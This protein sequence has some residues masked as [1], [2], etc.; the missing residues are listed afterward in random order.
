MCIHAFNYR[1]INQFQHSLT[2]C[3][4]C[5]WTVRLSTTKISNSD[6]SRTETSFMP[7]SHGQTEYHLGSAVPGCGHFRGDEFSYAALDRVRDRRWDEHWASQDMLNN[8]SPTVRLLRAGTSTGR[9]VVNFCLHRF[10]GSLYQHHHC[11]VGF[12]LLAE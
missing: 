6:P 11:A 12:L 5:S 1:K 4:Y 7:L 8:L 3:S 2:I 10:G 9:V